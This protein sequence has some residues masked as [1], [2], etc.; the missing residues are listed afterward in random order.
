MIK[1]YKNP[2]TGNYH[3]VQ[4]TEKAVLTFVW[5]RLTYG[6]IW[7]PV[8]ESAIVKQCQLVATNVVFN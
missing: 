2:V 8:L 6:W 4:H 3:A 7:D 1:V 5:S